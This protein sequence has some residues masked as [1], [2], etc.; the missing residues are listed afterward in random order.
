MARSRSIPVSLL[1]D[2]KYFE[3]STDARAVFVGLILEADDEGRGRAH[4]GLLARLFNVSEVA[5]EE[6]LSQ[7]MKRGLLLRYEVGDE[8][9][10]QW[11]T[12]KQW[13]SLSKPTP[14]QLPP[15]PA[16]GEQEPQSEEKCGSGFS[17]ESQDFPEKP[18]D[19]QSEEKC[20]SG[21]SWESQ[22][23]PEKPRDSQS[24]EEEEEEEEEK[25]KEKEKK[26]MMLSR[27][28][29]TR[30]KIV[31]FPDPAS[32]PPDADAGAGATELSLSEREICITPDQAQEIQ[33]I[34]EILGLPV[35]HQLFQ[36][37]AEFAAKLGWPAVRG[38]AVECVE[39]IEDPQR[40]QKR[41]KITPGFFRRWLK[42]AQAGPLPSTGHSAGSAPP[43]ARET[44]IS[45][46]PSRLTRLPD[47]AAGPRWDRVPDRMEQYREYLEAQ[48]RELE[49]RFLEKNRLA[50]E[51]GR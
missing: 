51:G 25:E 2:P 14:S 8:H 50:A 48:Q 34:A 21:F 11:R 24:E 40:N 9:F 42:R 45:E 23:F 22:D 44:R 43:A 12:W 18:R 19:S 15:P 30:P 4:I 5:V 38:E 20:G 3:L 7:L 17:W 16:W 35:S 41:R 13:E 27:R 46:S 47:R 49:A 37:A 28:R 36:V 26:K 29:A 32:S 39:Y 6:A 31:P 33:E 10:Y 1:K